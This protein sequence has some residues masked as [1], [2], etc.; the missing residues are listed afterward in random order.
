MTSNPG[1]PHSL[2]HY[3]KHAKALHERI[4]FLTVQTKHVPIIP[5]EQR[6]TEVVDYGDGLFGAKVVLGFM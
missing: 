3:F 1:A 6:I 5:E 2:I 4:V